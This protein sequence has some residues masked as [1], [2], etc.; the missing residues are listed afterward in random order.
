VVDLDTGTA[1]AMKGICLE[2]CYCILLV[3]YESYRIAS[4]RNSTS[5]TRPIPQERLK[6]DM[7]SRV[8]DV[9]TGIEQQAQVTAG[10]DQPVF[11]R[12]RKE[13]I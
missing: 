4:T 13:D 1:F 9:Y 6:H 12:T 5:E 7:D 8:I 11:D 3:Y 10:Y 2:G